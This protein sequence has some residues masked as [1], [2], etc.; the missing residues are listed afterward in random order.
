MSGGGRRS[1]VGVRIFD[2]LASLSAAAAGAL[3]RAAEAAVEARGRFTLALAGGET[4]RALYRVLA[5]RYGDRALWGA[6]HVFF[7]DERCVPPNDAASNYAMAEQEL[8]SRVAV[9]D[10]RV[11][12]IVGEA[13]PDDAARAYDALLRRALGAGGGAG[14][15][16]A[17][18]TFDL[19]L[20]GVGADGHTASLFPGD[21]AALDERERWALA[22]HA[23]PAYAPR[24]RIT[25][26]LAALRASRA[27]WVLAA[28]AGKAA[29]V[30]A[31]LSMDGATALPAALV[32]GTE[33]T[34][35]YLDRAAAEGVRDAV[36]GGGSGA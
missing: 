23:P 24:D 3:V 27:V 30:G 13:V 26:T 20:L 31:A 1:E 4:P 21:D 16:A 29:A 19:A 11:H 34:T 25:L 8:L 15:G 18:E 22:V 2:D 14:G 32:R 10:A 36:T 35:W 5:E 9:D 7:G 6:T 33:E 12:R 28:G 17:D